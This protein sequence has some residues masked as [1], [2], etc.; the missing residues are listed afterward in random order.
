MTF[1]TDSN[2]EPGLE[3]RNARQGL[4]GNDVQKPHSDRTP[5]L[6]RRRRA[7]GRVTRDVSSYRV[8]RPEESRGEWDL[9]ERVATLPGDK[10]FRP[11][12]DSDC[13]LVK[14]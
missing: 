11:L 12:S 13:P 9:M 5:P 14:K 3:P 1:F 8:R 4:G 10:A 7:E 6:R 2:M